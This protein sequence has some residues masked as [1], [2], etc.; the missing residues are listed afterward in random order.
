MSALTFLLR[1][2][3]DVVRS[4]YLCVR[5]GRGELHGL[6]VV[7]DDV[8]EEPGIPALGAGAEPGAFALVPGADQAVAHAA[9]GLDLPDEPRELDIVREYCTQFSRL[10]VVGDVERERGHVG[11]APGAPALVE[12]PVRLGRVLEQERSMS[13]GHRPQGVHVAH[14]AHQMHG[15][16]SADL[17]RAV[18]LE[19]RLDLSR[20]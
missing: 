10:Y 11:H 7:A 9:V 17:L 18:L 8:V 16:H 6:E 1:F 2:D 3:G 12:G 13:L 4:R 15:E 19:D 20:G 5:D 14:V